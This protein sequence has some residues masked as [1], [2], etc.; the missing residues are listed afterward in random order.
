MLTTALEA[1]TAPLSL[2]RRPCPPPPPSPCLLSRHALSRKPLYCSLLI[3]PKHVVLFA[4]HVLKVKVAASH[5][6]VDILDVVAGG[7]EVGGGVVGP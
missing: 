6:L 7:L 3:L 1:P 5:A 2:Y 4:L